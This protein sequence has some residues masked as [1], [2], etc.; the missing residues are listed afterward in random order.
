M[1]TSVK[2][3]G[4]VVK[5]ATKGH[6]KNLINR[7]KESLI[8]EKSKDLLFQIEQRAISI[9]NSKSGGAFNAKNC[10]LGNDNS[11]YFQPNQDLNRK[12]KA[13]NKESR[14]NKVA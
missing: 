14:L 2:G 11:Q 8:E 7:I 6:L 3:T 13:S 9:A 4:S 12:L 10:I 5:R 1:L